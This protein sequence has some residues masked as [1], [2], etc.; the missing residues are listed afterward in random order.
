MK[1]RQITAT[2]RIGVGHLARKV[3][4]VVHPET[5][6]TTSPGLKGPMMT[7]FWDSRKQSAVDAAK[8]F[9][10]FQR[11]AKCQTGSTRWGGKKTVFLFLHSFFFEAF[12]SAV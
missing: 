1:A 12:C 2:W 9:G 10:T 5:V 7:R 6:I 3:S 4:Q 8:P 11:N